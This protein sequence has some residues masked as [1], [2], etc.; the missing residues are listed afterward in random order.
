L[1]VLRLQ[2]IQQ[3]REF[4]VIDTCRDI[5]VINVNR[6]D[7]KAHAHFADIKGALEC[8]NLI[9]RGLMPK[10]RYYQTACKRLLTEEQYNGLVERRKEKYIN[11]NKGV[12]R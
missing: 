1:E 10:S 8:I 11:I 2:H 12:K 6:E 9:S 4:R 7:Y 5:V 3:I